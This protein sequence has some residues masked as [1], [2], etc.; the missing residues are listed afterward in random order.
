MD[1]DKKTLFSHTNIEKALSDTNALNSTK[2]ENFF[3]GSI[4]LENENSAFVFNFVNAETLKYILNE[5]K[6]YGEVTIEIFRHD[7]AS[8]A[9][10]RQD[11]SGHNL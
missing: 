4:T 8:E 5:A 9:L 6:T 11:N 2:E 7:A 3:S 10:Q 1:I